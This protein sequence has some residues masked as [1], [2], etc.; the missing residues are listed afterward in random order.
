MKKVLVTLIVV[1]A[2]TASQWSISDTADSNL[3]LVQK[4][5]QK[6]MPRGK[7]DSVA[8][9][10]IA[11]LYEAVYGSQIVYVTADG[12]YMVEGDIYDINKR[13]NLTEGKRQGGRAKA[14]K[15]I[16]VDSLIVFKAK[17]TKY[18]ITAFT[19]I[20][21]GYCRKLHRE[22]A[23]YNKLGIEIRYAAFPRSGVNTESYFKAQNVWC[24]KDQQKAMNFAKSGAKLEQLKTLEQVKDKDCKE[25]I[26]KHMAVAREV[27]VTGTPT[28][29][30]EDGQVLPGYVP[31]DRL[32]QI[33]D[34]KS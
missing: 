2:A 26:D 13:V 30:L 29:V 33:L 5:L 16:D 15:S 32:I 21:C 10:T 17:E 34:K 6:I 4:T 24:A 31:A 22:M 20:D 12:R 25:P 11:G 14:V 8:E 3:E 23:D 18:V 7:P 28:L 1:A 19:D 9:S 27:G